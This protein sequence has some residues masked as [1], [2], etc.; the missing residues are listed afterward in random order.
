MPD[1]SSTAHLYRP[2]LMTTLGE[3]Y[4]P[5]KLR[6][7]AVA[8]L[9]VAVVALPLSMAV[10]V[11]SGVTPERGLFT[12]IVGGFLVSA[13][14]GSRF[15][16]GGP[17]G[18]F[19][20]LV[21]ATVAQLGVNGLLLT[22]LVSGVMLTLVGATGLGSLIRYMP[23]P[24]T[25]GFT[26]G[27]AVT[28]FAS[29]ITDLFGLTLAGP[30][31]GPLLAK[32][33][34]LGRALPTLNWAALGIGAGTAAIIFVLRQWR[35]TWPGMLIAIAI[36]SVLA[37]V[38]Q[39][40]VET[41]GTRFGEIPHSLPAPQVPEFSYDLLLKVLPAALS[42]TLLG[43]VE[44][45]L[46]AKVA[47]SMTGRKHRSNMELV[48]Q[49]IANIASALFGGISVTGTIARTATNIRAG[50]RSPLSGMLHSVYL[51]LFMLVAAPLAR[52]IPLAA[53]AGVLVVVC[54]YMAE[55][56]EFVRLVKDW[57]SGV[58]LVPTFALTIFKDLT[59]GIVTGC[60][61]AVL[62]AK[63]GNPQKPEDA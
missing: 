10:A 15:Q 61:L 35:P 14:G 39:L 2:K 32:L 29:Q 24:V 58:V 59:F 62:F 54:W 52:Y 19:I 55:K 40:P 1:G 63:L 20:V 9:T 18:A 47:D 30:E 4:S 26:C 57:R 34:V 17:A 51:L 28:I 25:V 33:I 49:G 11:A 53:L 50:G 27:I 41:I 16:I 38:L 5:D 6:Q 60:I 44:S 3:G 43:G 12:A 56:E 31:P 23:H 46:S 36:A 13:L 48:A 8:G 42:F 7:D 22:V 45:L 21:A 37:L